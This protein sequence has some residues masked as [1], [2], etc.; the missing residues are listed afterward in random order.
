MSIN[1]HAL[2][3]WCFSLHTLSYSL[4]AFIVN[5]H[6][7]YLTVNCYILLPLMYSGLTAFCNIIW[8]PFSLLDQ[9]TTTFSLASNA[10]CFVTDF[11]PLWAFFTISFCGLLISDFL[12]FVYFFHCACVF[13]QF[14]CF[15]SWICVFT[16]FSLMFCSHCLYMYWDCSLFFAIWCHNYCSNDILSVL[17]AAH[18]SRCILVLFYQFCE[19]YLLQATTVFIITMFCNST[20]HPG[21]TIFSFSSY[22]GPCCYKYMFFESFILLN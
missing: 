13:I 10:L 20:M 6:T 2:L 1:S 15:N 7:Y 17:C 14:L 22:C 8:F 21:P 4:M 18:A 9:V 11:L 12:E 5:F 3:Y 19:G 16:V